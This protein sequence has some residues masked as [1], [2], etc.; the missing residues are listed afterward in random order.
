MR[1]LKVFPDFCNHIRCLWKF[2]FPWRSFL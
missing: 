2:E 1:T